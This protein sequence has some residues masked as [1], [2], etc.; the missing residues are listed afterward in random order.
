M[1]PVLTAEEYISLKESIK[2]NGLW[3]PILVNQDNVILDGHH[4]FKIC[5]EF[6]IPIKFVVRTF[7]TKLDEEIFVLEC[8]VKRRQL[9]DLAKHKIQKQLKPR[10][11]EL[12]KLK[13][14]EAGGDKKSENRLGTDDPK[15]SSKEKE[16]SR[17]STQAA[18]QVN[19][20]RK[21]AEKMDYVEE[22]DPELYEQIGKSDKITVNKAYTLTRKKEK[23]EQ[24]EKEIKKL[25]VHLPESIQLHNQKFQTLKVKPNSISLIFTDPPYHD[26][27]LY[28]FDDLAKQ[29]SIVLRDGGS[30][31]TYVGQGN[32]GKIINMME[33]VGLKF[34][35]PL[36]IKHTGPSASVFGK[37]ILVGCKIMLWFVKGKYDGEYVSDIK[38]SKFQG[39]ELHEWLKVL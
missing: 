27:F 17:A 30:V 32:I 13:Q 6:G 35:W 19:L 2:N 31:V 14:A 16:K 29:A 26:K 4:R 37:K 23:R 38:E 9:D 3:I 22:R 21:K 28:L 12:S 33:K 39:K 36:V 5:Q 11:Q 8:N 1:I 15:R 24:H 34:H 25:Q 20:S 10:Y 7:P 18:D